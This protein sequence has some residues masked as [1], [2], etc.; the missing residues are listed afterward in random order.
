VSVA[1][2]DEIPGPSVLARTFFTS[3]RSAREEARARFSR[4]WAAFLGTKA[5]ARALEVTVLTR[6]L[7]ENTLASPVEPR[8]IGSPDDASR[9]SDG[10][11]RA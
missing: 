8:R 2:R 4:E 9:V 7:A 3:A 11:A 5:D 10:V 1:V 6:E